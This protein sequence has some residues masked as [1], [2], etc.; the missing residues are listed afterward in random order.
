MFFDKYNNYLKLVLNETAGL[1]QTQ[2]A[3]RYDAADTLEEFTS[4]IHDAA[5]LN[6]PEED[7][8][9][10]QKILSYSQDRL[11]SYEKIVGM[12][13]IA[14]KMCKRFMADERNSLK[15]RLTE[16]EDRITSDETKSQETFTTAGGL[17]WTKAKIATKKNKKSFNSLQLLINERVKINE[18]ILSNIKENLLSKSIT[19]EIAAINNASEYVMIKFGTDG[20]PKVLKNKSSTQYLYKFK[21]FISQ[22][23]PVYLRSVMGEID[24]PEDELTEEDTETWNDILSKLSDPSERTN[25]MAFMAERED[26]L[27]AFSIIFLK[28]LPDKKTDA[29]LNTFLSRIAQI[30]QADFETI[31]DL[32][33]GI[34]KINIELLEDLLN[35][36]FSGTTGDT[37]QSADGA[38]SSKYLD[39]MRKNQLEL[40]MMTDELTRAHQQLQSLQSKIAK[41]SL[42]VNDISYKRQADKETDELRRDLKLVRNLNAILDGANQELKQ[43]IARLQT[44]LSF[45]KN[46]SMNVRDVIPLNNAILKY[47]QNDLKAGSDFTKFKVVDRIENGV[48]KFRFKYLPIAKFIADRFNQSLKSRKQVY[49]YSGPPATPQIVHELINGKISIKTVKVN[50]KDFSGNKIIGTRHIIVPKTNNWNFFSNAWDNLRTR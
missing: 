17:V 42:P 48:A 29:S 16:L 3:F 35:A 36:A 1:V 24:H 6:L 15:Q 33:L 32:Y 12:N 39:A 27:D 20:N 40:E 47:I 46:N 50:T 49:G 5:G 45:Y 21:L 11:E 14:L 7:K 34:K 19:E 25:S 18:Q 2:R 23:G 38:Q 30:K 31:A 28:P 37:H 4:R 41:E 43:E 26:V 10:L 44:E 22:K 9:I 8:S 13:F